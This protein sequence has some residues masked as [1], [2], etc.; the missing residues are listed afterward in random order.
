MRRILH[1]KLDVSSLDAAHEVLCWIL[2]QTPRLPAIAL[3]TQNP[4]LRSLRD[5][6]L[7]NEVPTSH[8]GLTISEVL[9]VLR[10]TNA[11]ARKEGLNELKEVLVDGMKK[12]VALGKREGEVGLVVRAFLGLIMDEVSDE[13]IANAEE[14]LSL[15]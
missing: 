2:K 11:S 6:D 14:M 9:V 5:P 4:L 7:S 3:P 15:G 1:T 10:H 12:G 8:R 13:L